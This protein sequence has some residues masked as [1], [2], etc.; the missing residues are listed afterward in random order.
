MEL[1]THDDDEH[2]HHHDEPK[3]RRR[4]LI[5]LGVAGGLVPSPSALL[6]LLAAFAVGR[7]WLGIV[8]VV[9]FG[10]GMALT[11]CIFGVIVVRA[12]SRVERVLDHGAHPS[13][14]RVWSVLP[15]AVA[16]GVVALGAWTAYGGLSALL[17]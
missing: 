16:V 3:S 12:R 5:T 9:A 6:V 14:E 17:R 4:S 11:L 13:L 8:L 15:A 10:V 1:L 7:A 2:D